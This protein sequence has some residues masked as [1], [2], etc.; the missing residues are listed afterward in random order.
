M[1]AFI[2]SPEHIKQLAMFAARKSQGSI[3]VDPRYLQKSKR[4]A[5]LH[6]SPSLTLAN[7]VSDQ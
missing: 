3:N 7:F 1:S 4:L 5:P 2:V 6:T